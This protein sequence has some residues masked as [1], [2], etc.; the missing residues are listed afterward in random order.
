MNMVGL[1]ALCADEYYKDHTRL[2]DARIQARRDVQDSQSRRISSRS[3]YHATD[4]TLVVRG[5]VRGPVRR[6]V[7]GLRMR[8]WPAAAK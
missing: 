5:A 1:T 6:L 3:S 7:A 4:E 2:E 8:A